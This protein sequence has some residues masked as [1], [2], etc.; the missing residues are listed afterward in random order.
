MASLPEVAD[1]GIN[2]KRRTAVGDGQGIAIVF[3]QKPAGGAAGTRHAG[4]AGVRS[5][6]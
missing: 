5:G 3:E 2:V 4:D 6:L 1:N